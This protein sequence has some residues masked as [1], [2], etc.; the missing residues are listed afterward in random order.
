MEHAMVI[1][2]PLQRSVLTCVRPWY[3]GLGNNK[4]LLRVK[5]RKHTVCHEW[6]ESTHHAQK[7]QASSENLA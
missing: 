4:R 2:S 3:F 7:M 6:V 5:A 1:V